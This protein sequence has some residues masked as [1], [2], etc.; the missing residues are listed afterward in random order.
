[1]SVYKLPA[2]DPL[3]PFFIY[4]KN[5]LLRQTRK[6]EWPTGEPLLFKK[7]EEICQQSDIPLPSYWSD[8]YA[9]SE[10]LRKHKK[11]CK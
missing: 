2:Q 3:Y 4:Q 5:A 7:P 10:D 6:P 9:F 8:K 1:M 11:N